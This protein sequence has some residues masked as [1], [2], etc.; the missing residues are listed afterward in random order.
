MIRNLCQPQSSLFPMTISCQHLTQH[1]AGC[2]EQATGYDATVCGTPVLPFL[3]EQA[4]RPSKSIRR[5]TSP[6]ISKLNSLVSG[7]LAANHYAQAVSPTA[8]AEPFRNRSPERLYA[9]LKPV[10]Q[11]PYPTSIKTTAKTRRK[12]TAKQQTETQPMTK[13]NGKTAHKTTQP[14][15]STSLIQTRYRKPKQQSK[16]KP[17]AHTIQNSKTGNNNK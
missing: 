12:Q 9:T 10:L 7:L 4:F 16:N 8:T 13:L 14:R 11:Q 5:T 3:L 15:V 6:E 2:F 17:T 1:R